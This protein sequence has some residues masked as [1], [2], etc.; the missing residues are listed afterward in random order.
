MFKNFPCSASLHEIHPFFHS[1]ESLP[2]SVAFALPS[3]NSRLAQTTIPRLQRESM[4]F[5]RRVLARK[6]DLSERTT[7]TTM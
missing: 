5:V 3:K 7:E 2:I 6:P 4:T 1:A